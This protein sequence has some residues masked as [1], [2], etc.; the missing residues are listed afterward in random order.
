MSRTHTR[1]WPQTLTD[2]CVIQAFERSGCPG[3][4][5]KPPGLAAAFVSEV[6]AIIQ[7]RTFALR[8]AELMGLCQAA[9]ESAYLATGGDSYRLLRKAA[10]EAERDLL[11]HITP[12]G[13]CEIRR[14]HHEQCTIALTNCR[15]R[16]ASE[17]AVAQRHCARAYWANQRRQG[18]RSD[19]F[20]QLDCDSPVRQLAEITPVWW[21][22]FVRS[23]H[24]EF[25][26]RDLTSFHLLEELPR[27]RKQA[28]QNRKKVLAGLVEEWR[29]AHAD[30]LGL[31]ARLHYHVLEPRGLGRARSVQAWFRS[32]CPGDRERLAT[33]EARHNI[34]AHLPVIPAR[35]W[36]AN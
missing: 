32:R 36:T 25:S 10:D 26:R 34:L 13:I 19:L 3:C 20:S 1:S 35:D 16:F 31:P 30:E 29:A 24:T 4:L 14:T 33:R 15:R 28:R 11:A 12:K 6:S 22:L 18:L 9:A 5:R 17:A 2:W 27:L 21:A 23:L 8:S 7:F